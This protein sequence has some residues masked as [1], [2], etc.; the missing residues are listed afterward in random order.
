MTQEAWLRIALAPSL[1]AA[2]LDE[3]LARFGD[4]EGIVSAGA[5][6][7]LAA[8]V[9]AAAAQ[10]IASPDRAAIEACARWVRDSATCVVSWADPAYPRLLRDIADAPA[11]LFIQ[12]DP[13]LLGLP[14]IAI[15]GSRNA[16]PD[17][18]ETARRFARYLASRGFCI[19][20]GLAEGVDAAAHAGA[21]DADGA[22][23]A[24]CGTGLDRIYPAHHVELAGR[25]RAAGA[26]VS[27]FPPDTPPLRANFPRRNRII[28]GL[29]LGTL[30]VEAGLTSGSL[31]T[32]RLAAEQG[33]EVFAIPGSIHNPLAKG[34]HR[35]IRQGA[36]LVET[37]EDVVE[38][39]GRLLGELALAPTASASAAPGPVAPAAEYAA[40]LE[41]MGWSPIDVDSLV[42][43]CGLT[44]GEVSSMLLILEM[45]G[46]VRSLSGGRYSRTP[47]NAD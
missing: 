27:E 2:R 26:L 7:L 21:L 18:R 6:R 5:S 32:A 4:A 17:G 3:L 33:R 24:V 19:T 28:S 46:H 47:Q 35:L 13:E 9:P 31:I 37:A 16:T 34:C 22:T 45:E 8:G 39:L 23:V 42:A 44:T 10:R 36:K 38:E 40:L 14:Q 29:S 1:G 15:V 43:R 25:I 30:V 41:A 11:A 12:G 20:S